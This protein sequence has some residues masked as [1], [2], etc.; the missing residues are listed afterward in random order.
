M[1][2]FWKDSPGVDLRV[3]GSQQIGGVSRQVYGGRGLVGGRGWVGAG[4][5]SCSDGDGSHHTSISFQLHR[6]SSISFQLHTHPV[7]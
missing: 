3:E 1:L 4:S 6:Y 5:C 2:S 7:T